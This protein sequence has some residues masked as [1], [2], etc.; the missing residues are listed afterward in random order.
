MQPSNSQTAQHQNDAAPLLRGQTGGAYS[1]DVEVDPAAVN[2][3]A[4]R[5]YIS[6]LTFFG[7]IGGFLFG[8]DTGV[9]SGALPYLRD[10]LLGAYKADINR[11]NWIQEIIVSA[12]IAGAAIGAA[13]GGLLS[14][15]AG[16]KTALLVGDGLFMGGALVMAAAQNAG[17]LITG[18]ALVGLGVGLASV[19]VPVY[20]AE[21]APSQIRATLV[22][23]NVLMITTGQFLAYFVDYVCTFVP[24]TWRWML[25]IAAL[26][27]LLQLVG[28]L[29]LPESPRWLASK[30]QLGQ[31]EGVLRQL[32]SSSEFERDLAELQASAEGAAKH[33]AQAVLQELRSPVVRSELTVGLGLQILQQLCGINTVMY[34]TPAILELAGF[35]DKRTALLVAMGPAAVN[36]VG[37]LLGMWHIDRCGRRKL[38]LSSMT[39]VALALGLLGFAFWLA[40]RDSPPLLP[41]APQSTCPVPGLQDCTQCLRQ[42]CGFCGSLSSPM[43]PGI[44]ILKT[45]AC[46]AGE[47]RML[48]ENGCPSH[49]TLYIIAGLLA[50][51]AAFS[52]GLGPVPWAV[53]AEIY[54]LQVRGLAS[55]AAATAN[56]VTN[57]VVSQTFLTLTQHLGGSGTFWLYAGIAL[58]G[59][60][61]VYWKL[62]ETNGLSL[63]EIQDAFAAAVKTPSVRQRQPHLRPA[64]PEDA[65]RENNPI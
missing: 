56:W 9:I 58:V 27:A 65:V 47:A 37:T 34:Y 29:Y 10:D 55:G 7:G 59:G 43:N 28:L 61:W 40:E 50:Y 33:S 48:Y 22:T 30:G 51:L 8:Y 4:S 21:A 49:Y 16:R 15:R 24:G 1:A 6:L 54:P 44:C 20:I 52:P 13:L 42:G 31:A 14:D 62:P 3:S 57:A 39:G 35:H 23:V 45:E 12:A 18:R 38:L 64:T 41:D 46:P 19:T 11:L 60:A 5:T 26:P 53:N 17:V 2:R 63:D 36:A 32:R 25:G